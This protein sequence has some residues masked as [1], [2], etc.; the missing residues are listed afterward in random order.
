R[1]APDFA[2]Y[3]RRVELSLIDVLICCGKT[4]KA[5][6]RSAPLRIA[7]SSLAFL[8]FANS[9]SAPSRFASHNDASTKSAPLNRD[10]WSIDSANWAPFKQEFMNC[11]FGSRDW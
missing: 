8:R 7:P 3:G 4:F 6:R 10:F 11:A 5:P 9:K 1:P 2:N